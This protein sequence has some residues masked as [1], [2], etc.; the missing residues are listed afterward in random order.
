MAKLVAGSAGTQRRSDGREAQGRQPVEENEVNVGLTERVVSIAAGSILAGLGIARR[1][2][3]GF[4]AAAAG[5]AIIYR[6]AIGRCP[7]YRSLGISTSVE[8]D[9]QQR[10]ARHGARLPPGHRRSSRP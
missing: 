2:V 8:G 7:L 9:N 10:I 5:G 4:L 1:S 3:P 6:G